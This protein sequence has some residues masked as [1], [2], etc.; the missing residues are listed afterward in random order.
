MLQITG[1]IITTT[2]QSLCLCNQEIK[3]LW[4]CKNMFISTCFYNIKYKS[5]I[6]KRPNEINYEENIFLNST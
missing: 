1:T 3:I 4:K 2:L 6:C 5:L